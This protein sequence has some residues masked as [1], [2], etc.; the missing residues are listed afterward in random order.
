MAD[1]D[2]IKK[3]IE[4]ANDS[5]KA[6]LVIFNTA[7]V[8][9]LN[10]YKESENADEIAPKLKR[11]E[12]ELD[13]VVNDL[14][15]KYNQEKT[16]ILANV[17]AVVEYLTNTGY[18]IKKSKAYKDHKDGLLRP[19]KD[20]SFSKAAVDK[21]ASLAQLK[22][23]DGKGKDSL[24]KIAEEKA[25]VELE[26]AKEQRD[27][28]RHK[29][30]VAAGYFVPRD[31]FERELAQRGMIFKYDLDSLARS[32]APEICRIVKGD[33]DLIP[34]LTEYLLNIFATFLHRYAADREFKVPAP[35]AESILQE[36]DEDEILTEE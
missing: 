18:K 28:L 19:E 30:K 3:L 17:L 25:V 16:E 11:A 26:K 10:R 34:D 1:Q 7:V 22:R 20:G 14:W 15:K 27:F 2:K 9:Y 21:Y 6:R 35:D 8:N 12:K 23:L 4:V 33:S 36:R 24:D 5:D 13:D 29:N 31:L 32:K